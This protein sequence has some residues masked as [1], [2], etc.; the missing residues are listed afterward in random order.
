MSSSSKKVVQ[1]LKD[2]G[3]SLSGPAELIIDAYDIYHGCSMI[4]EGKAFELCCEKA[5]N[6]LGKKVGNAIGGFVGTV[7]CPGGGTLFGYTVGGMI[8]SF[9]G[10]KGLKTLGENI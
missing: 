6:S 10:G 8:G 5:G 2:I 7:I 4:K 1:C 9:I 3:K